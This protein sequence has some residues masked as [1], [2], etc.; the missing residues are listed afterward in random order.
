MSFNYIVRR[1]YE[2]DVDLLQVEEVDRLDYGS[3]ALLDEATRQCDLGNTQGQL[4]YVGFDTQ[5]DFL[6]QPSLGAREYAW[7]TLAAMQDK[8][9]AVSI[10]GPVAFR[11]RE[12]DSRLD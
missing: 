7:M 11:V 4:Y 6:T 9:L 3:E 2:L 8:R 12:V 5:V 10:Y 1:V